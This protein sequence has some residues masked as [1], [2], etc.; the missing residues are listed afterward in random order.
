MPRAPPLPRLGL[1]LWLALRVAASFLLHSA[2]EDDFLPL[3]IN[4]TDERTLVIPAHLPARKG[5]IP[6]ANPF[7]FT[8]VC[9]SGGECGD[10]HVNVFYINNQSCAIHVRRMDDAHW[11]FDVSIYLQP[12]GKKKNINGKP[13]VREIINVGQ[14]QRHWKT[15]IANISSLLL[16]PDRSVNQRQL[17]PK[18]I[19][20]TF[21]TRQANSVFHW[22][23]YQSFVELNPEYELRMFTDTECRQFIKR[24]LPERVLDAYDIL[25]SPTFK[26]D[27]F[28]YAY[29]AVHGGCYFDHKMISRIPLRKV[30]RTN[31][32]LLVCSDA[33]PATGLPANTLAE[34]E[35]LYNA[36]ICSQKQDYRMWI[37]IER[38][39]ANIQRRHD[40]G[41][42][43]SL[44]GP[45]AFYQAIKGNITEENVRFKHGVRMKSI[46]HMRRKYEDYYVKEKL[47]NQIFLTKFY[48][49]FFAD[50]K[51]RYGTLWKARTVYYDLLLHYQ[52]WKVFTFPGQ[53]NC[54]KSDYNSAGHM[55]LK[56]LTSNSYYE[57]GNDGRHHHHICQ[58]IKI[59]V[60]NDETSEEY[61]IE[62]PSAEIS[63]ASRYALQLPL[64]VL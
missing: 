28:R 7:G 46:I 38:I 45:V 48:K 37:A 56:V 2:L 42:D 25:I 58:Y 5:L 63:S 44:T 27:L 41:S 34:T 22:N 26:A 20:Q 15:V 33:S 57:L 62:I 6:I 4:R 32:S 11:S 52:Q 1:C 17:I 53:K 59:V 18:T 36:V 16:F 21:A 19:I 55:V 3:R 60:V 29:L 24:N 10:F 49:G 8:N 47:T 35:R 51:E 31:D 39:V 43:L 30:L 23:A 54:V 9:N 40:A 12:I 64:Q 61:R 13:P 50:P 14:S